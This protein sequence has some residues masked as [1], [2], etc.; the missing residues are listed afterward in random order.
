MMD[1][2]ERI[3]VLI[4]AY[5]MGKYLESCIDSV[6]AQ[7]YQNIHILVVDDGSTDNT[8][9][10][11]DRYR[12]QDSRFESL[13]I[14]NSGH[15][16][17]R[18]VGIEHCTEKYVV[19]I[20]SDDCV[21][22]TF[23]EA[24]FTVMQE[25]GADMV[26]PSYIHFHEDDEIDLSM[27]ADEV[28]EDPVVYTRD[29]A[30]REL[31]HYRAHFFMPQKLYKTELFKDYRYPDV[32]VN[33]DVWAIHHLIIRSKKVAVS[34]K[35]IY[36][37]RQSPE[38]MT[39]NFSPKKVSAAL[40]ALDRAET[41]AKHRYTEL[42]PLFEREFHVQAVEFYRKCRKRHINGKKVLKPYKNKLI[43][44]YRFNSEEYIRLYN[45]KERIL[46]WFFARN[47]FI[48]D[49]LDSIIDDSTRDRER[50]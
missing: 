14:E 1:N 32:Q 43:E 10:I 46:H 50:E 26:N 29:E 27:N 22:T 47:Y 20:D 19:M 15:G 34:K 6:L 5:N 28:E 13:H 7:T 11:C 17:A 9:E 44:T 48:F 4:P 36:F 35:A 33:V 24:L 37:W 16:I 30:M 21:N 42:V 18:N 41:A 39:R 23:V 40:A 8:K 25:S 2:N 45:R 12:E 3:C 38:G 31:T 49:I